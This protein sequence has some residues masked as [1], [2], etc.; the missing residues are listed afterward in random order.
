MTYFD[1]SSVPVGGCAKVQKLH[2][3]GAIRRRLLDMGLTHGAETT[4]LYRSPS[5]DPRAYLIRGAVVALRTQEARQIEVTCQD[6]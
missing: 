6:K 4:C 1:L 2:A 5:G 3:E